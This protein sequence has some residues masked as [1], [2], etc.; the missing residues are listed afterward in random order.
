MPLHR[1]PPWAELVQLV[2]VVCLALPFIVA[3]GVDLEQAGPGFV[4][5]ALLTV[6]ATALVAWR[7]HAL[8]PITTGTALWLWV[9]ALAFGLP[10]E[11]LRG[12]LVD[13]QAF[14]LFVAALAAV[15]VAHLRAPHRVTWA[16]LGLG[17]AAIGW[18]WVWRHDIRLGGGLPFITLNVVRRVLIARS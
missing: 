8:N 16:L 5:G 14:G 9:G 17:V 10:V 7:G 4:L 3:G 13:T 11:S 15:A 18:A 6:P 2:P 12:W 1:N